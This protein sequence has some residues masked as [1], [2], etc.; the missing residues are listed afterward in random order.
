MVAPDECLGI[1]F[2]RIQQKL[3]TDY[4]TQMDIT[5]L[6]IIFIAGLHVIK[7]NLTVK[8]YLS[9]HG[10]LTNFRRNIGI[11]NLIDS[12]S[13]ESC[14]LCEQVATFTIKFSRASCQVLVFI[15]LYKMR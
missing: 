7:T 11:N 12:L 2:E 13:L 15:L 4:T 3:I 8:P 5:A 10:N 14:N 1:V 9:L 6:Q